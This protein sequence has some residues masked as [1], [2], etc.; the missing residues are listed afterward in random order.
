[1]HCCHPPPSL[2]HKQAVFSSTLSA[3]VAPLTR[4]LHRIH[5]NMR[6]QFPDLRLIQYDCGEWWN[7]YKQGKH[8]VFK[9]LAQSELNNNDPWKK[10]RPSHI[11]LQTHQR[12]LIVWINLKTEWCAFVVRFLL[13]T[14]CRTSCSVQDQSEQMEGLFGLQ[15]IPSCVKV[16]T[17]TGPFQHVNVC[18]SKPFQCS[19]G[20]MFRFRIVEA[21][22]SLQ[23]EV[24][25]SLQ[26][27]SC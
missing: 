23:S 16:W 6:T 18:W 20:Y 7:G 4:S 21:R 22:S 9:T 27:V 1:M 10:L 15:W 17:L 13:S 14:R 19:S 24:W 26:P 3:Q 8:S 5:C 25:W 11:T 12:V 2:S